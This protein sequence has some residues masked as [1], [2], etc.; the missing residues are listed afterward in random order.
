MAVP[1]AVLFGDLD[2]IRAILSPPKA[3]S[4]LIVDPDAVLSFAVSPHGFQSIA[5][6]DAKIQQHPGVVQAK[7]APVRCARIP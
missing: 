5:G 6:K 2:F 1:L 3:D 4:V 7:Q